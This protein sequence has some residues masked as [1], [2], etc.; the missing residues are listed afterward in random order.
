MVE[1]CLVSGGHIVS[2]LVSL[3][4]ARSNVYVIAVRQVR[5]S[6]VARAKCQQVVRDNGVPGTNLLITE[7]LAAGPTAVFI[8]H[9]LGI[10]IDNQTCY[11]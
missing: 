10:I 5:Y 6:M 4:R 11:L 1:V 9:L 2:R 8:H 3:G 7:F